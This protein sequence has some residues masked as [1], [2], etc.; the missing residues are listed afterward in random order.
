MIHIGEL[1]K[2]EVQRQGRSVSWLAREL[3]CD[4]SN[5]YDIFKRQSI[6]TQQL[7]RISQLLGRNFFHCYIVECD[8]CFS[9][10]QV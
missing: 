2:A 8:A 9:K 6:D 5:V 4:R 10:S 1:I 3:H 7:L